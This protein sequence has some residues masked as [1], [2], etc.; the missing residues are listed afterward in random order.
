LPT[1]DN[2]KRLIDSGLVDAIA[3]RTPHYFHPPMALDAFARKLPVVCEKPVAVSVRATRELNEQWESK[4][5]HLKFCMVFQY[6]TMPIWASVLTPTGITNADLITGYGTYNDGVTN[7]QRAF[8][9]NAST[10]VPEPGSVSLLALGS[11]VVLRR[12]RQSD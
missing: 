12:R 8:L 2:H 10:L 3:I 6:R 7:G 5:K 11:L 4:Y 9:I 1:F